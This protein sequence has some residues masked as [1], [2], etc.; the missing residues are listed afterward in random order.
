MR[1]NVRGSVI[2]RNGNVLLVDFARK[3]D[4]P[5]PRFPGGAAR[6]QAADR[7]AAVAHAVAPRLKMPPQPCE[8]NLV[9]R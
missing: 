8:M 2:T 1:P 7:G 5:G 6:R 9:T 3:P 4:P